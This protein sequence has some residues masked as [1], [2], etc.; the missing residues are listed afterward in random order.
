MSKSQSPERVAELR[1]I[2]VTVT[3]DESI[4]ESQADEQTDRELDPDEE[5]DPAEV[6]DGLDDAVAGSET[7]G[8]NDPAA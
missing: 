6:A 1:D 7:D 3:G 2:F 5:F 8:G 4:T